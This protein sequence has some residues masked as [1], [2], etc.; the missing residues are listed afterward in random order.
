MT[1]QVRVVAAQSENKQDI[2]D[3]TLHQMYMMQ[4]AFL[5]KNL[6]PR[7]DVY[8]GIVQAVS[9]SEDDSFDPMMVLNSLPEK[10]QKE[11][12]EKSR[13]IYKSIIVS[14]NTQDL[15]EHIKKIDN[16]FN[17][18]KPSVHHASNNNGTVISAILLQ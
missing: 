12:E 18:N 1:N 11:Y 13:E 8:N 2:L 9:K 16:S 10:Y 17:Y 5:K 4:Y 7:E 15:L 3:A 6:P 14:M